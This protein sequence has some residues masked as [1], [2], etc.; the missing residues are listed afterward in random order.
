MTIRVVVADDQDLVR[1][2]F[3]TIVDA[4]YPAAVGAGNVEVSQR[5][6]DVVCRALA[7][8]VPLSVEEPAA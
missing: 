5:V 4:Q 8:A 6:A 2:G 3:A 7:L 1:T